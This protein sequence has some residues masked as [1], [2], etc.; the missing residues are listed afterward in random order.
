MTRREAMNTYLAAVAEAFEAGVKKF[1][2]RF[3]ALRQYVEQSGCQ[4]DQLSDKELDDIWQQVK[5]DEGKH[6]CQ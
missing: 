1:E 3:N 4:I 6:G 5:K 2:R